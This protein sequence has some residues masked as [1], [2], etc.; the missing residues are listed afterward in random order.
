MIYKVVYVCYL[1]HSKNPIQKQFAFI[2][3]ADENVSIKDKTDGRGV[4]DKNISIPQVNVD[5]FDS[6]EEAKKDAMK[7][8]PFICSWGGIFTLVDGE[9]EPLELP[10]NGEKS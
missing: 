1:T 5:F 6:F 9:W 3:K 7:Y 4:L 10:K 2:S 8:C